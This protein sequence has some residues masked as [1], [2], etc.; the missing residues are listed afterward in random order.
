MLFGKVFNIFKLHIPFFGN[1][2]LSIFDFQL[3]DHLIIRLGTC[4]QVTI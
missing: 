2:Q 1:F 4:V 3:G